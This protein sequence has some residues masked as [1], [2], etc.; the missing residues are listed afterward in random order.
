[1]LIFIENHSHGFTEVI[2]PRAAEVQIRIRSHSLVPYLSTDVSTRHTE[3]RRGAM[4][5]VYMSRGFALLCEQ[6]L[7]LGLSENVLLGFQAV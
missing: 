6:Y 1:M 4:V 7:P 3:L 2:I 5:L